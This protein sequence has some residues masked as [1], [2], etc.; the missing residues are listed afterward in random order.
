MQSAAQ[1]RLTMEVIFQT[2]RLLCRRIASADAPAMLR[3][4]GDADAMRWVG[5]GSVLDLNQCQEWIYITQHNYVAKGYGMFALECRQSG[6]II[7][8]CGIVHPGGQPTAEIKYALNRAHWGKGLATEA[9][10]AL[11]EATPRLGLQQ[12]IATVAP[13]NLPSHAVLQKAGMKRGDLV[14]NDDG[15]KSQLFDWH[16]GDV[17][18]ARA[19]N[20]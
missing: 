9:V 5:G 1:N 19:I 15:S 16:A 4:Y 11:L 17:A 18:Q 13:E 3:V 20:L 8:F 2:E 7:G 12:V 6:A 14:M 10:K